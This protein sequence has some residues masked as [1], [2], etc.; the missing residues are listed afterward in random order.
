MSRGPR[1]R[2]HPAKPLS[3]SQAS[4]FPFV[5]GTEMGGPCYRL[6]EETRAGSHGST[7]PRALCCCVIFFSALVPLLPGQTS[8]DVSSPSQVPGVK[9]SCL[10]IPCVFSFPSNVEVP[11]G[12]TAIWYF[13][14]TNKRQVV[15]HSTNPELVEP[16]F[17]GRARLLGNPIHKVCNLLLTDLQPEDSG[18]YNFR[19]E[20]TDNNRWLDVKGTSVTVT[21]E[22]SVPTIESPVKLRE[23]VQAIFNC[24][25]PYV[26]PHEHDSLQWQGQDLT[27]STTSSHQELEPTGVRQMETLYMTPSWQ[28]HG[29][30][31]SCQLSLAK[32]TSQ[33]EV[34]LRVHYAPKGVEIL[35]SPSGRNILPGDLVTLTCRVNSSYPAVS[36]IQWFKD[37]EQLKADG[38]VLQL[39]QAAWSDSG[40]YTCQAENSVGSLISPP[41]SL[42]VFMAEVQVSPAGPILENQTVTLACNTPKEAPGELRYNWYKNNILLAGVHSPTLHLP[43]ATRTDT[44]FYFC[45]VQNAQGRERSGPVGVTVMYP[46]RT[47]DMTAFLETKAGLVGI[48]HCSVVSEPVA[49][50]VLSHGDLILASSSGKNDYSPRFSISMAPNSLH[51]EIQ[52]LQPSDSGQY[53]CSANNSL[54]NATSSLDFF[55]NEARLLISPAA[56]VVEGQAVTLTCK[57]GLNPTPNTRFSWYL[58]GAL[59]MEGSSDSL[60]LPE[61]SSIDAGSYHCRA[62]DGHSSSDPSRPVVL[63]VL[64]APRQPIFTAQLD[65]DASGIDVGRPGLLLCRVKSDPPA[66]LQL[67][68]K[69]RVVATSVSVS[70]SCGPHGSCSQRI[71]ITK[72]P[73]L[74]RVEIHNPV[75]EDEGEYLCEANNTLGKA[76]ISAT[77]DAQATRLLISPSATLHEGAE[78]NLTCQVNRETPESSANFS[79]FRN[80]ALW[81]QGPL[82][83]MRLRPVARTDAAIYTCCLLEDGAQL[84]APVVLS[85]HYPPDPPKLS[86]LLDVSQGHMA[87]FVCTVDSS[88]V[89]HLSLF[90]EEHL[91][92][93]SQRPQHPSHSRLQAKAT[94]NSLQLEVHEL[95]LED[96]GSYRCE[97][98][99]AL[100]S[101][102]ASLFFKVRE[103]W[104]QVSPSLELREGQDVVLSCQVP[105]EVPDGTSYQWYQN[106]HL[107]Q[108]STSA[109]LRIAAISP[110][111][112]G[113]YHCQVQVP[114][115]AT[116]SLAAPV[117]LHVS[118]A[119][120]HATLTTLLATGPGRRS[121]LL[122][123]VASDPPSQLRL[124]HGDHLVATTLQGVVDLA[125]TSS[126]LQAMV[127]HNELRLDMEFTGLEDEGIYTCEAT[128]TLGQASASVNFDV[129]AV[130]VQVWPNATVQ[131]G[132]EVALICH[133]WTN[134]KTQLTYTWYRDG[135]ECQGAHSAQLNVTVK[136]ATSY[137]CGASLPGQAPRLSRP[138]TL[139]VL[140]AP[141][142]LRL[143]YLLES[144]GGQLALILCTVDSRPPAQLTLSHAGRLV[145]SSSATSVP[146]ILRLELRKPR[147]SDE[148][149]YSCS[150]H[151]LLGQANTSLELRLEGVQVMLAPSAAVPEGTPVTVTCEDPTARAPTLYTWY[152]NGHWLQEGPATSLQFHVA[153]RAQAGSYSCQVQDAQGTR[154]SRPVTLQVLYAPRD[155][156]LSSFWD[157]RARLVAVVQ[158]TVDSEP[159]AEL[160]LSHHGK[161]L[162]TSHEQHGSTPGVGHVQVARNALSLRLQDV[163]VGDDDI[164]VCTAWN[165][166]GSVST[167]QQLR[168][169]GVHVVAEPGLQVPEGAA[170]NL[171]CHLLGGPRFLGNT[172]F[173][174]FW[175]DQPLHAEPVA[176]LT[177]SQ[178]AR[179]QAGLY[180]C[181]VELSARM[182]ATSVPVMLRVLYP[183][184]MPTM[185]VFVEPEGGPQGILDCRVDSEPPASLT[186]HLGSRLVASSQ[187]QGVLAEPHIHV[188]ASPNFLRV[189]IEEL[190]PSDQGEY[191][192]SASN[193][194][195]S[196]SASAY[197]GTRAARRLQLFQQ[198]LWILGFLVSFLSLLLGLGACYTWRGRYCHKSDMENSL[199]MPSQRE[200]MQLLDPDTASSCD[201][202]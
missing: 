17:R 189:N 48:L 55:A 154:S 195:G 190:R 71:K 191:V 109:T 81:A 145:A 91:L 160:T 40:V 5:P 44:G 117:S 118:Y 33:S 24:S 94:A 137:Y 192:C 147:L 177:F 83:T 120:R 64:Y 25:T 38:R 197:F 75:L 148:G 39:S 6:T 169:E 86:A 180:S 54:G 159:P 150:A 170:L 122:C 42:H 156:V 113:A 152:H 199:E 34:H 32:R 85:V 114:G 198:L 139:N 56:Q 165:S 2:C 166:L 132:K 168:A 51:L 161:V 77:F 163:P 60:L 173:T 16:R 140:Y 101:A 84:S 63:T 7:F 79:W 18:S 36:A 141:R 112:T 186:L 98:T 1:S 67:L 27:R 8:W 187:P 46:P 104:V 78:A 144:R 20:I 130:N 43:N 194:L 125:N 31:L 100:G 3:N 59:L 102:N 188:L 128:N 29:Q 116:S 111:Q 178:V 181:Q 146:N 53:K 12:I 182:A 99:N 93:T 149:L 11:D 69:G 155:P 65:L 4:P 61:A 119:P 13:D 196:T 151:S 10:L 45:E 15:S 9:G 172:T 52:D 76:S 126:Q 138:V 175:N 123:T 164:Y 134:E 107:L 50:L 103:A 121:I 135:Q 108:E 73:N 95:G 62:Q 87:V 49:T 124:R 106:G 193:A 115:A 136:N 129:Q 167:T 174:W 35:L 88:P 26:C 70:G 37:G 66:Q 105:M 90:R 41:V 80:G 185:T 142:S 110:R 74:L 127:S 179:A 183:P 97:A 201:L 96:S 68:H 157:S 23:G 89:A 176:T 82:K 200:T 21:D 153:T 58:N 171:S 202:S 22:P 143:T 57:N 14:H 131:E 133:V 92:A 30:W 28:D 72:A 47:P 162:A 158:C 184:K 19:F